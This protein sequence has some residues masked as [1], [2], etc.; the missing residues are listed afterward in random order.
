MFGYTIYYNAKKLYLF[1]R[2]VMILVKMSQ[3]S[4][5]PVGKFADAELR[6]TLETVNRNVL[7]L[8]NA[9]NCMQVD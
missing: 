5:L 6:N 4:K 3:F 2:D 9:T 1:F 8:L 7:K